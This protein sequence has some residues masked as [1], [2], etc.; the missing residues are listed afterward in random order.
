MVNSPGNLLRMS[1]RKRA[2]TMESSFASNPSQTDSEKNHKDD[3]Q[4]IKR[5]EEMDEGQKKPKINLH[6][7]VNTTKVTY[8]CEVQQFE[9]MKWKFLH[10]VLLNLEK[11]F[12]VD[13]T[14]YVVNAFGILSLHISKI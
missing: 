10:N 8:T 11:R 12:F 6:W 3:E 14:K 5:E 13:S 7:R 4:C 9:S 2:R 1:H